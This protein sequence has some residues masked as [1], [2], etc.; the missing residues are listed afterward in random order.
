MTKYFLQEM[1]K[2]SALQ[3]DVANVPAE[4]AALDHD[5]GCVYV[6]QRDC[7]SETLNCLIGASSE[8]EPTTSSTSL[9]WKA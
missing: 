6:F 3:S 7:A 9:V 4:L 1:Q 8:R 5:L 2:I